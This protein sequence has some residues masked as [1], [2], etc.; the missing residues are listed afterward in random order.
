MKQR[1]TYLPSAGSSFDPA[2]IKISDDGVNVT[3]TE[4]PAVEKRVTVGLSELPLEVGVCSS[5]VEISR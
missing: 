2:G 1:I 5:H 4:P 3:A